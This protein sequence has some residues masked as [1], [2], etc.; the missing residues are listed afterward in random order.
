MKITAFGTVKLQDWA[1][2]KGN[3]RYGPHHVLESFLIYYTWKIKFKIT[4]R[5][6]L[7]KI[8]R[9]W[10]KNRLKDYSLVIEFAFL[11][12]TEHKHHR[13]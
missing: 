10:N 1:T 8:A 9:T 5:I 7:L 3:P 11:P 12:L 13:E 2:S 6:T 4:E